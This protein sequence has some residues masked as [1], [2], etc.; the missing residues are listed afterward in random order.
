MMQTYRN[1]NIVSTLNACFA[2]ILILINVFII[3]VI[4]I[5]ITV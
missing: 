4:T 5:L 1:C 2:S 3:I